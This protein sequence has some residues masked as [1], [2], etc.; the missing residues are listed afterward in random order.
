MNRK[1]EFWEKFEDSILEI[2]RLALQILKQKDTLPE[3]EDDLNRVFYWCLVEAN[4]QLQKIDKGRESPPIYEG[5]NQPF[6]GDEDRAAREHKRPDFQWSITDTSETDPRKSS[7]QF[8][9]ECKR[10]GTPKGSWILNENYVH[11]GIKRFISREFGYAHGVDSSAMLGYIQSMDV[12]NI[13]SK[14]NVCVSQIKQPQLNETG[15]KGLTIFLSHEVRLENSGDKLRLE[16][17]WI[18][19]RSFFK[20]SPI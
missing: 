1:K 7:K 9:L 19:L 20:S 12:F 6:Y 15:N 11:N 8:V 18:D 14:V 5:N 2:I 10:L 3:Q 4:Y 16:H 17:I 13:L